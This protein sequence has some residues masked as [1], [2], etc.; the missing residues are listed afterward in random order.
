MDNEPVRG[1]PPVHVRDKH[2]EFMKG[3]PPVFTHSTDPLDADD[4]LRTVEK[5]LDITQCNDMEKV[6]YA[7]GQLQGAAQDWWDSLKFGRPANA[8][9]ITWAEFTENFRSYHIPDGLME[10]KREEF[11]SLRQRSMT[12][13]EY[14]DRFTQ[15]S[16]YAPNE[17]AK[18]S[19][20]QREFL[21]GLYDDLRL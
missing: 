12:V 14:R 11:R 16:R 19:D 3:R 1:P 15:L 17:V 13:S 9:P 20:K 21:K 4:W 5:Q 10:L 2:G 7:S 6:L 8:A 18:D